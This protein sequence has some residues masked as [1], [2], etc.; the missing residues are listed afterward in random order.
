MC[1]HRMRICGKYTHIVCYRCVTVWCS[2]AT[3]I[4][5]LVAHMFFGW[6]LQVQIGFYGSNSRFLSQL[7]TTSYVY[8]LYLFLSTRRRSSLERRCSREHTARGRLLDL[9]DSG[10]L[11]ESVKPRSISDTYPQTMTRRSGFGTFSREMNKHLRNSRR[12]AE[13]STAL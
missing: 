5:Q 8:F 4:K 1:I 10:K 13:G 9:A 3:Y 7:T 11:V 12:V 6:Y 2:K